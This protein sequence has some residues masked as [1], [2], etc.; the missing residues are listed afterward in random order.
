MTK[1]LTV[2][3]GN[4]CRSPAAA[5]L[6]R[7][8]LGDVV[9][10]AS[11]GTHAVPDGQVPEPMLAHLDASGFDAR[12]HRA[13]QLTPATVREAEVIATMTVAHRTEV[14]KMAPT[15]MKKTFAL[16]ELATAARLGV[17]LEGADV[18]ARISALP[19]ALQPLRGHLTAAGIRDIPDPYRKNAAAYA[20]AYSMIDEDCQTIARWLMTEPR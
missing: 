3:T 11:A 2:C 13:H 20:K 1:I 17:P 8:Y 6:L 16:G 7:A 4:I 15:A 9:R 10:P 14:V 19:A 18:K 12:C 5:V